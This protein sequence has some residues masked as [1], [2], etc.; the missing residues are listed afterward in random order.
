MGAPREDAAAPGRVVELDPAPVRRADAHD[1]ARPRRAACAELY[2]YLHALLAEKR[3]RRR[4]TT[5][6]RTLIAAEQDGDRLSD[7]ELVNLVLNVLVG[8][9]DT[10]Q[11]QLAHI[12]RLLAEHPDQW[13]L[14]RGD[15]QTYVPRA[16]EE[17]LRF[18]PI[19]PFTA[20]IMVEDVEYRDVDVPRPGR[21]CSSPRSPPTAT[22]SR[23]ATRSTSRASRQPKPLTFGA[24]IHYC[25]GANLAQAEMQEAL[26]FLADRVSAFERSARRST[27]PSRASTA[28]SSFRSA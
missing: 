28:W 7:V 1:R 3:A 2:E 26:T 20:R 27:T 19:T 12:V 16:V 9:V 24:G 17:A 6:S 11:S 10:T 25:L 14:V 15:P 4:A 21:S 18:E 13:A 8:G 23:T 22:A 5:S